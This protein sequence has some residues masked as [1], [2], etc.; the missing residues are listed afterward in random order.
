[1]LKTFHNNLKYLENK[2]SK[3]AE[4]DHLVTPENSIKPLCNECNSLIGIMGERFFMEC[5]KCGY[6]YS[7]EFDVTSGKRAEILNGNSKYLY[8]KKIFVQNN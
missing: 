8:N 2:Y 5:Q 7:I 3:I 6:M 4:K 1:M